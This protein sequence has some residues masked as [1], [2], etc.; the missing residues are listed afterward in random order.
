VHVYGLTG[1]IG[2]GKSA[3]ASLLEEYGIPVVS[4]DELS[5][6]V[7]A[8]GTSS[9]QA[10]VEAF[11]P[12]VLSEDGELDRKAMAQI[13]FAD[14]D[15]R[16]QLESILHPKIRE[17]FSHVL[18]ALEEAGH[19]VV[20]YEVPLL[21]EKKLQGDMHAVIL[22]TAS[23]ETRIARVMARD[24]SSQAQVEARMRTQMPEIEKRQLADYLIINEGDLDDLRRE[25]QI[26]ISRFLKL[27]VSEQLNLMP[28]EG[29]ANSSTTPNAGDTMAAGSL[30]SDRKTLTGDEAFKPSEQRTV[31][32]PP[33]SEQD[34]TESEPSIP[35]SR[36]DTII[37]VQRDAPAASATLPGAPRVPPPPSSKTP[38]EAQDIGIADT[39]QLPPPPKIGS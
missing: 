22:V 35:A 19:H 34:E 13:V 12:E 2:S 32:G 1:G 14:A 20:V 27:G 17:R 21:F 15:K 29:D 36:V 30:P 23:T 11:G 9:L 26:L 7:V 28:P 38:P 25:V 31:V 24:E 39:A 16:R 3:V 37:N 4:A 5:R 33:P 18:E 6:M 8:K 10:V